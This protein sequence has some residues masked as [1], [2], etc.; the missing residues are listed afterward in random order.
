[1]LGPL[2]RISNQ[3]GRNVMR[4]FIRNGSNGGIPGEQNFAQPG[5]RPRDP[6]SGSRVC[7]H[8]TNEAIIEINRIIE[9]NK[10]EPSIRHPQPHAPHPELLLV[11]GHRY[12]GSVRRAMAPD[13]QELNFVHFS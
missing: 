9:I 8:S 3:S 12:R 11:R 10:H 5:N 1:M 2:A 4:S 13:E 7:D 6:L